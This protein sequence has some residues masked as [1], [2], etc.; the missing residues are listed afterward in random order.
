MQIRFAAH[1]NQSFL[2]SSD[3][4]TSDCPNQKTYYAL[5]HEG[6]QHDPLCFAVCADVT[7]AISGNRVSNEPDELGNCENSDE[8]EQL[9]PP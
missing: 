6:N 8:K 9:S 4:K 2:I 5:Q 7:P 1:S 3:Q